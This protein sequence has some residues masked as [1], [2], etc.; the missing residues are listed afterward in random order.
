MD[1][2]FARREAAD[3]VNSMLEL[4]SG[5]ARWAT[6]AVAWLPGTT[7]MAPFSSVL[8]MSASQTTHTSSGVMSQ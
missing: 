6:G 1:G 8:S 4:P 2:Q 5:E 7:R 3:P